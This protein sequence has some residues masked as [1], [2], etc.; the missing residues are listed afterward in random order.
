MCCKQRPSM[1]SCSSKQHEAY[2]AQVLQD[3]GTAIGGFHNTNMF[4]H[5]LLFEVQNSMV[6]S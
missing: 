5:E 6:Q 1:V 4:E 2:D 3:P